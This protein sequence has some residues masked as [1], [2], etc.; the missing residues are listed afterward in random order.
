MVKNEEFAPTTPS[1]LFDL[2]QTY[3][4]QILTPILLELE[5]YRGE[6]NFMKWYETLT[7]KLYVNVYQKMDDNERNEYKIKLN[8]T[9]KVI[10]ENVNVFKGFSKEEQK[11]HCVKEALKELELW[12]KSKMEDKGLYGKGS[13][14]DWDEI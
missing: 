9:I 12:L 13:E 8:S 1:M 6:S 5:L 10:N 2:R 11:K 7:D 3:A 14:Y 4:M